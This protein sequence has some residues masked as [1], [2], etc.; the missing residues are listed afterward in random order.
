[1][2]EQEGAFVALA[3]KR[4]VS[5]RLAEILQ[6]RAIVLAVIAA[7]LTVG[8]VVGGISAG[9]LDIAG[10]QELRTYL[11]STL[12]KLAHDGAG[13][14]GWQWMFLDKV[15]K[16][17]GLIWVLG[18]S[19]V[20]VPLI[21]AVIFMRGF[22][23]G[24]SLVF[25]LKALALRGV[26]LAI[27]ALVPQNLFYLPG[28]VL[29]ATG[30]VIFSGKALQIVLGKP[31]CGDIYRHLR[32]EGTVTLLGCMLLLVGGLVDTYI[33]PLITGFVSRLIL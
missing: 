12:T 29:A 8:A 24:F 16:P 32:T 22:V 33:T 7:V 1:V 3:R 20:G 14:T 17:A 13:Y 28:L 15:L 10:T 11:Q 18:M 9:S 23:L 19:V 30:A 27:V 25:I 26:L 21:A 5:Y 4:V 6:Q 2:A 31:G